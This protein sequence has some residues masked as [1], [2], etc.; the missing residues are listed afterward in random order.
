MYSVTIL[1]IRNLQ[2]FSNFK[3]GMVE[4]VPRKLWQIVPLCDRIRCTDWMELAQ[5]L[6]RS[7]GLYG[8]TIDLFPSLFR[9]SDR[10][11]PKQLKY[12]SR[13]QRIRHQFFVKALDGRGGILSE[14]WMG[15]YPFLLTEFQRLRRAGVKLS[16]QL[17]AEMGAVLI[18]DSKHPRFNSRF[19]V[20]NKL[21][22]SLLT[23]RRAQDFL[24]R[25]NIVYRYK[26]ATRSADI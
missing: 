4:E 2:V 23:P 20:K 26:E 21:F 13:R 3:T 17:V 9:S 10:R 15:L 19:S 11:D 7:K 22:T 14:H 24:E 8:R 25:Y 1:F 16:N 12:A 5:A 6:R 18:E